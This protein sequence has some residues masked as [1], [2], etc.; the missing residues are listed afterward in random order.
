MEALCDREKRREVQSQA[1]SIFFSIKQIWDLQCK[2]HQEYPENQIHA[3]LLASFHAY[4]FFITFVFLQ[5]SHCPHSGCLHVFCLFVCLF[6]LGIFFIYISNVI[7]KVPHTL[8]PPLSL[9][10]PGVPLY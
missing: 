3:Q 7:P 9:L 2:K 1:Q 6:L 5:S 10:G 4:I 8:T